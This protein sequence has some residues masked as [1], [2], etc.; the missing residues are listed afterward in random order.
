MYIQDDKLNLYK[1]IY[2]STSR[3]RCVSWGKKARTLMSSKYFPFFWLLI[4]SKS[5][6][7]H[8]FPSNPILMSELGNLLIVQCV[9]A[10]VRAVQYEFNLSIYQMNG[11]RNCLQT[12]CEAYCLDSFEDRRPEG[13][14][15]W[16]S[17]GKQWSHWLGSQNAVCRPNQIVAKLCESVH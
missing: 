9:I 16:E 3:N 10:T 13:N 1:Y 14:R 11:H 5:L 17:V 6:L 15:C 4:I 2:H 12:K 8:F 7:W